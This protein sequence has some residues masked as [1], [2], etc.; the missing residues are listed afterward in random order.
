M[1]GTVLSDDGHLPKAAPAY[2]PAGI[3]EGALIPCRGNAAVGSEPAF[4]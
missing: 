2:W 1:H 3:I 4:G